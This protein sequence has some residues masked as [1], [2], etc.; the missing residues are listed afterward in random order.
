MVFIENGSQT[1]RLNEKESKLLTVDVVR[2]KRIAWVCVC[3][4]GKL[5]QVHT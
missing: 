4:I 5:L 3:R 2:N 1:I